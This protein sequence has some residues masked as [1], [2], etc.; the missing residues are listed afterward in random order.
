MRQITEKAFSFPHSIFSINNV[1]YNFS[2]IR[3]LKP[4]QS[5]VREVGHCN[6]EHVVKGTIGFN[7]NEI[8]IEISRSD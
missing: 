7:R 2:D 3:C 6:T 8:E 5:I 1:A 4:P